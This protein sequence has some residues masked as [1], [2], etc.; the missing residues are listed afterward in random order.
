MRWD[1]PHRAQ[2]ENPNPGKPATWRATA[3]EL[4][5]VPS[6]VVLDP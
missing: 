4:H 6:I 5:P 3:W 1:H 2:A